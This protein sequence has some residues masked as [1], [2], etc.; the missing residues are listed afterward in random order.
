MSNMSVNQI[1]KRSFGI[2][3]VLVYLGMAVLLAINYF[4]W[5]NSGMRWLFAAVF[6]A[7]GLYRGY[8][9][10]KGEHTYGMRRYDEPDEERYTTYG[11]MNNKENNDDN[12]E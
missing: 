11:K 1:A 8:R 3:M 9:E 10:F 4:N 7:Y 12:K 2:F 6:A 5:S